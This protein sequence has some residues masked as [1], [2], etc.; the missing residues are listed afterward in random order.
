MFAWTARRTRLPARPRRADCAAAVREPGLRDLH[1]RFDG[2]PKGVVIS[3]RDVVHS[4]HMRFATYWAGVDVRSLL[5]PRLTST[6]PW[7]GCSGPSAAVA[8]WW[9]PSDEEQQDLASWQNW[10]S[11]PSH[12]RLQC[13]SCVDVL[14]SVADG[15]DLAARRVS[16]RCGGEALPRDL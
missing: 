8:R 7:P 12:P 4:T 10:S 2:Q 16:D 15:R 6:V 11:A 13:S 5:F 3:H 9:S 14:L 1:F